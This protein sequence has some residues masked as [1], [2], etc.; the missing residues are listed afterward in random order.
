MRRTLVFCCCASCRTKA[1]RISAKRSRCEREESG[2]EP[3][4]VLTHAADAAVT[5][6]FS[7]H[8]CL[9]PWGAIAIPKRCSVDAAPTVPQCTD[10]DR[11]YWF[12]ENV[13]AMDFTSVAEAG[14]HL[15]PLARSARA[16][17]VP[18]AS[19]AFRGTQVAQRTSAELEIIDGA[20]R[21]APVLVS[22]HRSSARRPV[23]PCALA[24]GRLRQKIC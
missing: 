13:P 16:A 10:D 22:H 14:R 4:V 12:S 3:G 8:V 19:H 9:C 5:A 17:S 2:R 6:H 7:F 20:E 11:C 15:G 1:G 21:R 24:G 23:R 18:K